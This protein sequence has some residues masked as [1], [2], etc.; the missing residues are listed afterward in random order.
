[1]ILQLADRNLSPHAGEVDH[2]QLPLV[3]EGESI[4]LRREPEF[5]DEPRRRGLVKDLT[6][7]VFEPPSIP[8][9][10]SRDRQT[11]PVGRPRRVAGAF[12]DLSRRSARERNSPESKRAEGP[13][14]DDGHFTGRRDRTNV[15]RGKVQRTGLQGSRTGYEELSRIGRR[16]VG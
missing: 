7:R 10:D 4:S 13:A 15:R 11:L 5:Q 9:D 14:E 3:V 12:R 2:R 6:D 8:V 1:K 16:V